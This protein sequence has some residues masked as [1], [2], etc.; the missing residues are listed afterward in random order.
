M[1]NASILLRINENKRG[2]TIY[3][4]LSP[5]CDSNNSDCM[6]LAIMHDLMDFYIFNITRRTFP[7]IPHGIRFSIGLL[8]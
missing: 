4:C 7:D 6:P 3:P 2:D 8:C 1:K 5:T